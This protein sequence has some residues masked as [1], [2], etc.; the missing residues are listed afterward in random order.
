MHL[1]TD[2]N[3]PGS[4]NGV[5]LAQAVRW[6]FRASSRSAHSAHPHQKTFSGLFVPKPYDP[7]RVTGLIDQLIEQPPAPSVERDDEPSARASGH[8]SAGGRRRPDTHAPGP[9]SARVRLQGPRSNHVRRSEA[10]ARRCELRGVRGREQPA[11]RGQWLWYLE[12]GQAASS[13]PERPSYRNSSLG[14][15][16]RWRPVFAAMTVYRRR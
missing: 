4:M 2:V 7:H 12:L 8:S 5:A 15:P 9:V 3:M 11:A 6:S 16:W 1:F 14:G 13:R 10:C